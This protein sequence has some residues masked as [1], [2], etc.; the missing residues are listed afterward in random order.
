MEPEC[1]LPCSQEP[2]A[3]PH[4]ELGNRNDAR[5]DACKIPVLKGF[6]KSRLT[7][8]LKKLP[9]LI[10]RDCLFALRPGVHI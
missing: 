8:K 2:S 3:G 4:P 9:L 1:S 6:A 10:I 5:C 7:T